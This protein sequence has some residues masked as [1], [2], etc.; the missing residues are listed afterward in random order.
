M[1]LV[2]IDVLVGISVDKRSVKAGMSM[3]IDDKIDLV[4]LSTHSSYKKCI[5]NLD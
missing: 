1:T 3:E 5:N 2:A 4:A